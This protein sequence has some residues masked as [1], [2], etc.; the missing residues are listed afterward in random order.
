MSPTYLWARHRICTLLYCKLLLIR[1]YHHQIF[2][3]CFCGGKR[4][5]IL[6]LA[7]CFQANNRPWLTKVTAC[8]CRVYCNHCQA[9]A[10]LNCSNEYI[11]HFYSMIMSHT[12]RL[13]LVRNDPTNMAKTAFCCLLCQQIPLNKQQ[14]GVSRDA[15]L[16]MEGLVSGPCDCKH[17][18]CLNVFEQDSTPIVHTG[19]RGAAQ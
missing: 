3:V 4:M 9:G 11:S 5:G 2:C 6:K 16:Q 13:R 10:F 7:H 18:T 15:T 14:A 19:F 12:T 8:V 17:P 1:W